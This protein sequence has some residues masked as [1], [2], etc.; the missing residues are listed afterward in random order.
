MATFFKEAFTVHKEISSRER[1]TPHTTQRPDE[2]ALPT[3]AVDG[4]PA[5]FYR[6]DGRPVEKRFDPLHQHIQ[7]LYG[8]YALRVLPN[9][10]HY[11]FPSLRGYINS[12]RSFYLIKK[13]QVTNWPIITQPGKTELQR[14]RSFLSLR[15][16][17][18]WDSEGFP[19]Y[20]N[21]KTTRDGGGGV[22]PSQ[23]M[24]SKLN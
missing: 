4:V 8:K 10:S 1:E 19:S 14:S 15:P 11:Y 22:F 6:T 24:T 5:G 16:G 7:R 21:N 3:A 23:A 20:L 17:S 12:R 9:S 18:Y 13:L 2:D